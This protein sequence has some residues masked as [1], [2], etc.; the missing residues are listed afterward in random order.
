MA[1]EVGVKRARDEVL[2]RVLVVEP[3]FNC[4]TALFIDTKHLY[5]HRYTIYSL[6]MRDQ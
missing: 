5:G 1:I 4:E 6:V 2:S 3:A